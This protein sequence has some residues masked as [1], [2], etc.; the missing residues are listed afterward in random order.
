MTLAIVLVVLVAGSVLFHFL[1]PWWFTPIASNWSSIDDTVSITF[2]VTGIVFVAVN[3]FMAYCVVRY[4]HTKG[5]QAHYEPENKKLEWSLI[6]LTTVGIVAML[7]PGLFVW[8]NF[9]NPPENARLFEVVGQQWQW[10]YRFPG[11]D[12]V[13]G[14]VN[15]RHVSTTNPFGID[16]DDAAGRDDIVVNNPVLHLPVGQP[17]KALMRSKDVLHDFAVP[18]F[19]VK[20]DMVPG[21]VTYVWFTPTRI[22]TFEVLCQELCGI[23]HF[24]MRGLV[25]VES[26]DNFQQWLDSQP[27]F[28]LSQQHI[29]T[30][31]VAAGQTLY[32]LC[33]TCHGA[34]GQ[35]DVAKHAPKLSGQSPA[36]LKRQLEYFKNDMRGS[37]ALDTFG[38]QMVPM[39]ATL[40]GAAAIDNV[41]AYIETLP[42]TAANKTIKGDVQNGRALYTTCGVC[43]GARGQ[44]NFMQGVPRLAGMDDWYMATQLNHFKTGV[45]GVHPADAYGSQMR[46][47]AAMLNDEQALNDLLTYV[48]TL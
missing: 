35:G 1:S 12:G 41:V 44:G 34:Q 27:T 16:V 9:V 8:A 47:M 45:R 38:Q 33:S 13:L 14:A 29:N 39:A 18:Q 28:A 32:A 20:M 17:V 3:L 2:W 11:K 6:G 37:H 5:K 7:A 43:H 30:G 4:R 48:N 36:Y 46:F 40:D 26:A 23:A 19:R 15:T 42:D 31:D 10:S 21:Q 24:A 25:V 22:G